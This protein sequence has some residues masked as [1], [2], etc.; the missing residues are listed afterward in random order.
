MT[1]C[2]AEK[3]KQRVEFP[4]NIPAL[5]RFLDPKVWSNLSHSE[6]VT[7]QDQVPK[8][9]LDFRPKSED[10][11]IHKTF[12]LDIDLDD[13][14]RKLREDADTNPL[15]LEDIA[16]ESDSAWT[17]IVPVSVGISLGLGLI[18]IAGF[19]LYKRG[20]LKLKINCI[21]RHSTPDIEDVEKADFE[22]TPQ[23]NIET[24]RK[25]VAIVLHEY[26]KEAK[27][28]GSLPHSPDTLIDHEVVI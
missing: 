5:T 3:W 28:T 15:Q 25:E 7:S 18:A 6:Y 21:N 13:A 22:I 27:C 26:A 14:T 24:L 17:S 12:K 20:C 2:I 1:G 11:G 8:Y 19:C 9:N 10:I 23:T 16:S 4:I